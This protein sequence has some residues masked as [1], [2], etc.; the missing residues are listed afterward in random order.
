M[1]IKRKEMVECW[2]GKRTRELIE[3]VIYVRSWIKLNPT[4]Q[5]LRKTRPRLKVI[6]KIG[7]KMFYRR[8]LRLRNLCQVVR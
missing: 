7:R 3:K 8:T 4:N 5:T 2:R 6:N 1:G